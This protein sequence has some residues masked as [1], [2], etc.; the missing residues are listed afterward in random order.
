[1]EQIEI[2]N[3]H[4]IREYHREWGIGNETTQ[5]IMES[6]YAA[7]YAE[8]QIWQKNEIRRCARLT[9]GGGYVPSDYKTGAYI[10]PAFVLTPGVKT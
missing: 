9:S 2:V 10:V 5:D 7:A 3:E 8:G 4:V 6:L 1:M